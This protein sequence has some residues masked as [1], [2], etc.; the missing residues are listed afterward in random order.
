M[1]RERG[2]S[3]VELMVALVMTLIVSGAIY[4]LMASGQ[5]AF[6]REPA[7]IDRQQNIRVALDL[8]V[9]DLE[10]AGAGM[11]GY[12]VAAAGT[13]P[14]LSQI[15]T[16]GLDSRGPNVGALPSA[17]L[18]GGA[19]ADALEFFTADGSC[20]AMQVCLTESSSTNF[21]LRSS[22]PANGCMGVPGAPVGPGF[23]AYV[24]GSNGANPSFT[25]NSLLTPGIMFLKFQDNNANAC[26]GGAGAR[27]HL[28]LGAAAAI[29]DGSNCLPGP[30]NNCQSL[31]R[32]KR[33]LYELAGENPLLPA[34][35]GPPTNAA[36]F[37]PPC[38]WRSEYGRLNRDGTPNNGPYIAGGPAGNNP[39][40]MVARGIDDM[41]IDYQAGPA[42]FAAQPG[43]G[44]TTPP[45]LPIVPPA[46]NTDGVVRRVRVTLS[47]RAIGV[48]LG[49]EA[50]YASNL[51]GEVGRRGQMTTIVTPRAALATL[52]MDSDATKNWR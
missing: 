12:L 11:T 37:N 43:M 3:L 4:G 45:A 40:E 41:Q 15:F 42:V 18:G 8:I 20:P 5:G 9:R 47:A 13:L 23:F 19:Q 24:S 29:N 17:I 31:I 34:S 28:T 36:A 16:Q 51:A 35:F 22:A 6:K 32:V 7:L 52:A 33:V 25:A 48:N 2:F 46:P 26:D 21:W 14:P 44:P 1:K 50:P 30:N 38:L 39:W 27:L 10:N 49:G